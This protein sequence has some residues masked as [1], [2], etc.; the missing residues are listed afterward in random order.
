M[1]ACAYIDNINDINAYII[2]K[3]WLG[4]FTHSHNLKFREYFIFPEIVQIKMTALSIS[5]FVIIIVSKFFLIVTQKNNCNKWL[6][7]EDSLWTVLLLVQYYADLYFAVPPILES[8][9]FF[10]LYLACV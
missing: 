9:L 6:T 3:F 5:N 8:T 4:F 10:W 2:T 1:C 7:Q